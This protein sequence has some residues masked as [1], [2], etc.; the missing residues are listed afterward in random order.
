[1]YPFYLVDGNWSPF[2]DGVCSVTCGKGTLKRTRKC[3]NPAPANGGK[4]CAGSAT[5]DVYCKKPACPGR[6]RVSL[7][8][9]QFSI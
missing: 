8:S 5:E 1:M 6:C 3:N 2:E 7:G 4:E 9:G